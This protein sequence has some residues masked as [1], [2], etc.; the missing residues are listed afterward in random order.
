MVTAL[1]ALSSAVTLVLSGSIVGVFYAFS[2]SVMPGLDAI[3]GG[4]AIRA[5]QSINR[6]IQNPLF[7]VTFL[8][9]PIAALVTGVLL[10][11]LDQSSA[12][13]A[14]LLAAVI[15]VVGALAPTILVNVPMN[16]AL[17]RVDEE[18][19]T[20]DAAQYWP[21]YSA[22]WTR[23]N[24]LRAVFSAISLLLTGLGLAL[25]GRQA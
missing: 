11:T 4:Q 5:M 6:V 8:G 22:R 21:A 24:T 12:A 20:D 14:F 13:I 19:H 3:K 9:T 17:D 10:L 1:A 23:W 25:W 15:Y 2:V 7:L 16:E 18:A